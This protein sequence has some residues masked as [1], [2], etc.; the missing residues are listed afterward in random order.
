MKN[1]V[2][3]VSE[4]KNFIKSIVL[5]NLLKKDFQITIIYI[6]TPNEPTIT[7]DKFYNVRKPDVI[8]SLTQSTNCGA[9]SDKLYKNKND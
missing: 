1:I 3:V 6:E 9:S 8:L 5:D 4:Q 2:L 7:I